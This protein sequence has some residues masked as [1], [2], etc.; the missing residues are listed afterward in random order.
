MAWLAHAFPAAALGAPA[1]AALALG[2]QGEVTLQFHVPAE[3]VVHQF[4]EGLSQCPITLDLER[5]FDT[6]EQSERNA[7]KK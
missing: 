7:P 1:R 5:N 3:T 6:M 2:E 4:V